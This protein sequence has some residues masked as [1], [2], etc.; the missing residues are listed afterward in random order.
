MDDD[1]LQ[2]IQ[3]LEKETKKLRELRQEDRNEIEK[4]RELGEEVRNEIV[5]LKAEVNG[6]KAAVNGIK[7]TMAPVTQYA[8]METSVYE[9]VGNLEAARGWQT[10]KSEKRKYKCSNFAGMVL[11]MLADGSGPIFLKPIDD[12]CGADRVL[13]AEEAIR[14]LFMFVSQVKPDIL[15]TWPPNCNAFAHD[16]QMVRGLHDPPPV[17]TAVLDPAADSAY[18]R[19]LVAGFADAA[20]TN[21][22]VPAVPKNWGFANDADWQSLKQKNADVAYYMANIEHELSSKTAPTNSTAFEKACQGVLNA[23]T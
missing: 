12:H 13:Y 4:L 17:D 6:L 20:N 7:M 11:H 8:L 19:K 10:D 5:A 3:T 21:F 1:V 23:L 14:G 9:C 2:R 22:A 16:G 15:K 18:V